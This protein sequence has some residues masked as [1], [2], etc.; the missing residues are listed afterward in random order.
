MDPE[1]AVPIPTARMSPEASA[2]RDEQ[3]RSSCTAMSF[4]ERS[5]RN[6]GI[7]RIWFLSFWSLLPFG[8]LPLVK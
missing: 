4:D 1:A 2:S 7:A 5:R 3:I 8:F 6:S